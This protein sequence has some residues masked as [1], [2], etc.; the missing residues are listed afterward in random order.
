MIS[1]EI[2]K[3]LGFKD[4]AEF[5]FMVSQ[6]DCR[7]PDKRAAFKRWQHEDGTKEDLQKLPRFPEQQKLQVWIKTKHSSMYVHKLRG[8]CYISWVL[9]KDKNE[10]MKFPLKDAANWVSVLE[11]MSCEKLAVMPCPQR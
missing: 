8:V 7:T 2:I 5:H 1:G 11:E 6:V 3:S 4:E 10:A 9:A